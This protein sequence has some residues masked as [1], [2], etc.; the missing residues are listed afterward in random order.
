MSEY[1]YQIENLDPNGVSLNF[2]AGKGE[3]LRSVSQK[4]SILMVGMHLKKTRG[5]I[6]TLTAG[7]LN[8]AFTDE[9]DLTYIASQAEDLGL[10]RKVLLA[11]SATIR[12]ITVCVFRSPGLVY[13]HVGS[14][15]SLYRESFFI[16]L[17][18]RFR[19]K[20]IT[21]FHAGDIDK[22]YPRQS[23]IGQKFI[24]YALGLSDRVIAVSQE[25]A[26]QI[27]RLNDDLRVVVIPNAIDTSAFAFADDKDRT[28]RPDEIV[29]LLFVGATGKLKGERDLINALNLLKGHDLV[30]KVTMLG[31]GAE[32]LRQLFDELGV[33]AMVEHLGAVPMT[34]RVAFY[35][36]ADIFVLPTYA[37]AMPV[38]VIEAMAAG[39]AVITTPVGGIP[40]LITDG[41]EGLL[42]PV[43]NIEAL[44]QMITYLAKHKGARFAMGK[45]ARQRVCEQI[46]FSQYIE[47]LRCEVFNTC[48]AGK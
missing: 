39:L 26:S 21:H 20:V 2:G 4:L 19:K 32:N 23:K 25:S 41:Q 17:G 15:A 13:V 10:L 7:I 36:Q 31:Y 8:S 47:R 43:G 44:A 16:L 37:E 6:T 40:E 42:F 30:I 28:E 11:V 12:F 33:E 45:R 48:E 38:S 35:E 27:R 5:G 18:K 29:R 24:V 22:Y 1:R 9:Y 3:A 14:N 34:E 46:N